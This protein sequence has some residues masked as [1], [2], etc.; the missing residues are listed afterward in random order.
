MA[1]NHSLLSPSSSSK[2]LKSPPIA[3]LEEIATEDYWVDD[4]NEFAQEGTAA[5]ALAEYKLKKALGQ[6]AEKPQSDLIDSDMD[7]YTDDYVLFI[8][9]LMQTFTQVPQV[10]VEQRLDISRWVPDCF[11]TGDC[12]LVGDQRVHLIDLKY[13]RSYIQTE[14]NSQLML[15]GLGALDLLDGIYDIEELHLTI[16]Q[17]RINNISTWVIDKDALLEWAEKELKP[18]AQ[19]AYEGKGEFKPGPWLKYTK[20]KAISK[21][22]AEHHMKLRKYQLK[23]AHLL[24]DAE[25]ED[26]LAHVDDLVDWAKSVKDYAEQQA[27]QHNKHWQGFK[28]VEGRTRRKY[29]DEAKIEA[30][31]KEEGIEDIHETK[32]IPLTRL[33]KL[34]GKKKF[35]DSFGDLVVKPTGKPTLVPESDSRQEIQRIEATEEFTQL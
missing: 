12:L 20:L 32:L 1:K 10:M 6:K 29:V 23:E 30:R 9:E 16:Y 31:A 7:V 35:T 5:H 26:V 8:Q 14:Q 21:D 3:R 24:T 33:E 34:V 11:G 13:G 4:T 28:L 2:W 19:E 27:I 18:K 17:P 25:I 22:R 15:Y